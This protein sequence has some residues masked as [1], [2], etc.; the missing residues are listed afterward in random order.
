MA[1]HYII[2]LNYVI[3]PKDCSLDS[4]NLGLALDAV[5]AWAITQEFNFR[6][7]FLDPIRNEAVKAKRKEIELKITTET[8]N[9]ARIKNLFS[10]RDWDVEDEWAKLLEVAQH[11]AIYRNQFSS[12]LQFATAAISA[13][14]SIVRSKHFSGNEPVKNRLTIELEPELNSYSVQISISRL[15][16][17]TLKIGA[18]LNSR[19]AHGE[20]ELQSLGLGY[21]TDI[22]ASSKFEKEAIGG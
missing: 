2:Y 11:I 5:E 13:L 18:S 4:M 3:E 10:K 20:Y 22:C 14:D 9:V 8:G 21:M 19:Q 17:K 16:D 12:N 7:H 1:P 6:A 15:M